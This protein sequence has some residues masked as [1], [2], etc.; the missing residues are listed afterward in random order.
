MKVK[1]WAKKTQ[2]F[3]ASWKVEGA[4]DPALFIRGANTFDIAAESFKEYKL[5]FLALKAGAYKFNVTFREKVTGEYIFYQFNVTVEES[6]DVQKIEIISAVRESS[7]APIC[8]EN[9]TNEEVK[10][11]KSQFT[12]ANDYVEIGPEEIAIKP[13]ES[14]EFNVNFRPLIISESTCDVVFKNPTLGEFKYQLVLKGVAPT[15]QRSLAFKC[16][17]GQDQ[18]QVFKFQHFM[19]KPVTY[20]VKVDRAD[21][22]GV[23]DFKLEGQPT[24]QAPAADSFKGVE[25]LVNIRYEP[26]T[27]GDSRGILKLTSPEGIEYNAMLF[28]RASA[29][30]PQGPIKCPVGAK[31]AGI[32]F[33][34]PLN[35]KSEFL[36]TFDNVNFSLASKLPGP[37]EPG[38]VTNLQIKYDGKPDLPSTGRM[39]VTTKG[40]PP[41]IFYLQGE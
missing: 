7:T 27:I 4:Q 17:L 11:H 38:K 5:N 26:F 33:K 19:K 12:F 22:T 30:Q 9:P 36:V 18:M 23:C 20:Q 37:L 15:Q 2:R 6:K 40:L 21:G 34:N 31:P 41:W 24:V 13:H 35:E 25:C 16:S 39:I 29:P 8:I 3:E 10:V 14:R 28:G 1:N 32:D